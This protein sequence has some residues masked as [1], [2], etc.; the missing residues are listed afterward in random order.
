MP[1]GRKIIKTIELEERTLEE[2]SIEFY[3]N[4][5]IKGLAESTQKGYKIYL[6]VFINWCG[7]DILLKDINERTLERYIIYN[8]DKGNKT[9]S[10]ATAMNHLRRFFNFCIKRGYMD[11]ID[12]IIPKYQAELKE[13]YTDDEMKLLLAKPKGTNWVEYRNW[14]MVNYFFSTGQRLS[15]VL[16]IKVKDLDLF[17]KRVKLTWNKDKIQK[18]MPLSSAITK[19]LQDYVLVSALEDEDY[20]F[21]EYEGKRL[22]TRSAEDSIADYNIK[23]GVSKTS[24]HLFRH[25]FA[26]NYIIAGGN[27]VKLQ[28]LLNHKT[29]EMTMHYVNLYSTDIANDLDA[30]NPLDNFK[31]KNYHPTKRVDV[32]LHPE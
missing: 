32:S 3:E 26:K 6:S 23:R 10:I 30:F 29:I 5:R 11:S 27:P 8:E 2:A 24:I 22:K 25:T 16:N 1:R 9:V 28:H 18:Y 31:R 17:N 14:C 4:N 19:I 20:L 13:P 21:P 7:K 12:I 15:T